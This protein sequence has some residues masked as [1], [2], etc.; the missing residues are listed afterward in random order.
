MPVDMRT[1][2]PRRPSPPPSK[3][4]KAVAKAV[5][6]VAKAVS[7]AASKKSSVA[8]RMMESSFTP[9]KKAKSS[10]PMNKATMSTESARR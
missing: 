1:R 5:K 9:A 3:A 7:K 8:E 10:S 4:V 2:P 6:A